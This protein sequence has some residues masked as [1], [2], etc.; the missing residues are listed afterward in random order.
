MNRRKEIRAL[1]SLAIPMALTQMLL[2]STVVVDTIM[3]GR[4]GTRELAALG[5]SSTYYTFLFVV[6]IGILTAVNPLISHAH[7]AEKHERI[8][9]IVHH[10]L[11][12]ALICA[13]INWL[14]LSTSPTMLLLL[15]QDPELVALGDKY[16]RALGWGLPG[17]MIFIVLRQYADAIGFPKPA[18]ILMTMAFFVNWLLD[19]LW[20]HGNWGFPALGVAGAGYATS[21]VNTL[22]ALGLLCFTKWHPRFRS[23]HL[24]KKPVF[25]KDLFSKLL[26]LGIPMAGGMLTEV[27]YFCGS[28]WIA[29]IIG[30]VPL[31]AHQVA[32]NVASFTFMIPLGLAFA[33]SVRVGHFIGA[34]KLQSAR[35]V[36]FMGFGLALGIEIIN[37]GV[38]FFFAPQ[39]AS[40]YIQDPATHDLAVLLLRT[41]ALFQIFDGLQVVGM[42]SLRGL[43]DTQIPFF[44]TVLAYWL[45]GGPISW[46]LAFHSTLGV[47]GIWVGMIIS[48]LFAAI[49]HLWRFE[50]LS[51]S[52][53]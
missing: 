11:V 1:V 7:G 20:I 12:L 44:N 10:G 23:Y 41:G 24:W 39:I 47:Q 19:Y 46:W 42:H 22:L 32:L 51:R 37:V 53:L 6:A 50:K 14:L 49:L 36:G 8:P 45:I 5:I 16:L 21:L 38:M 28:T 9:H 4:L 48:L 29:G 13:A 3:V 52:A 15:R 17:L 26:K 33:A 27:G 2:M 35:E 40:L 25:E 34:K 31:A 18:V 30:T 43:Q